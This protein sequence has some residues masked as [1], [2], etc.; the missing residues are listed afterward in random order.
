LGKRPELTGGGLIRSL[1]GWDQAKALRK[2]G[3]RFKSDERILGESGFVEQ[4]LSAANQH[5]ARR[6]RLQAQGVTFE[7]LVK[8]VAQ[9]VG[10]EPLE[11]LRAGKQPLGV[12]ARD[13]LCY[14]ANRELKM[15]TVELAKILNRGQPAISRSVQRG[16]KI[17][18][19]ENLVR[20]FNESIKS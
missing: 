5:M 9:W 2:A 7:M 3:T 14:F 1:G 20:R 15:S 10:V 18:E 12:R 6:C 17:V 8:K 19:T 13:I 4:V 16:E 11:L